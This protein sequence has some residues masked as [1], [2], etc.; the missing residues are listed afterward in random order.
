M[1]SK[2]AFLLSLQ[3]LEYE[4]NQLNAFSREYPGCF[5]LLKIKLDDLCRFMV[6]D[7]NEKR[8]HEWGNHDEVRQYS[9]KLRETS[10]KALCDMEKYQS[11]LLI[12]KELEATSYIEQLSHAVQE[13]LDLFGIGP[14]SRVFFIGSGAYPLS[15]LTIAKESRAKVLCLDIDEE[16]VELGF[17]VASA[18][19]L[20]TLV[21]FAGGRLSDHPF[22]RQ[23]THVFIASLVPNKLEIVEEVKR[24]ARPDTKIIVRYGNGLKSLFNY[25]LHAD[26]SYEWNLTPII[27]NNSLYDTVLMESKL[28]TQERTIGYDPS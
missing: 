11:Q 7:E 10:V 23:T 21:D 22:I 26:L 6:N 17:K 13:E 27:R 5:E 14:A 8:W 16:A 12:N 18:S 2:Y 9:E 15:A 4:I 19:G 25:P 24:V 1:K 28:L 20:Q 3:S